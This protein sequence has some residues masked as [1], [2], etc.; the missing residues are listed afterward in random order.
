MANSILTLC[1]ETIGY[2][3]TAIFAIA[4][5]MLRTT[6]SNFLSDKF[7]FKIHIGKGHIEKD[8]WMKNKQIDQKLTELRLSTISDRAKIFQFQNGKMYASK[9]PMWTLMCTNEST[10][11]VKTT[12]QTYKE[13][14]LVTSIKELLIPFFEKDLDNHQYIHKITPDVCECSN[15][16]NCSFP[17]GVYFYRI[18]GLPPGECQGFLSAIDV[19]YMLSSALFDEN[20]NVVGF[21]CLDYC[22]EDVDLKMVEQQASLLCKTAQTISYILNQ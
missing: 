17:K 10:G 22:W 4:I 7:N 15:K 16:K 13:P 2:V 9:L 20:N 14:V 19:K 5:V 21:L 8:D 11:T 12:F 18:S 3:L 1:M 6:I